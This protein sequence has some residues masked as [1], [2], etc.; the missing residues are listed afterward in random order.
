[1]GYLQCACPL[2]GFILFKSTESTLTKLI[3]FIH[4]ITF[5]GLEWEKMQN[6]QWELL[7]NE[8]NVGKNITTAFGRFPDWA[9]DLC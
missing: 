9:V 2:K 7:K 1:M 6:N 5:I 8:H 3:F 4:V